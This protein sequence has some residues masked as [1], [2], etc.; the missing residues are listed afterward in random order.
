MIAFHVACLAD[1]ITL[2]AL[3]NQSVISKI[4]SYPCVKPWCFVV[5]TVSTPSQGFWYLAEKPI[6]VFPATKLHPRW[7]K[8]KT[9]ATEMR[10]KC[11]VDTRTPDCTFSDYFIVESKVLVVFI[12]LHPFAR[13]FYS[14]LARMLFYCT[15]SPEYQVNS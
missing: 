8:S 3:C 9:N 1:T 15:S 7:Q 12:L 13:N 6:T 10:L 5:G 2:P 14:L 11:H 4:S